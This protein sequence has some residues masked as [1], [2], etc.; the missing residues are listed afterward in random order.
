[1][2]T[3]SLA[4]A[5]AGGVLGVALALAGVRGLVAMAPEFLP[6]LKGIGVDGRVLGFTLLAALGSALAFGLLPALRASG[7]S[8]AAA[9]GGV[10]STQGKPAQRSR[11]LLVAF[12]LALSL[13]L[14]VGA[15]LLMR[16]FS[17]LMRTDPGFRTENLLT[18]SMTL[19]GER[20][21]AEGA[22]ESA[23]EQLLERIRALP[24]VLGAGAI[25]SLPLG[26]GG[27]YLGRAFLA[28]GQ[29]EPPGGEDLSGMWSV[30]TPG[31]MS[32]LG[33]PLLEGRDFTEADTADSQQVMIVS[34]EFARRMFPGQSAVGKRIR[35]WR[36][37]NV[38]RE[39]VGVVGDVR[40]F[41]ASDELRPLVFV[42]HRQN[43]WGL[44]SVAVR[45][46]GD[47]QALAGPIREVLRQMDPTLAIGQVQTMD[48][49]LAASV[50]PWKF[51]MTLMAVFAALALVLA[52]F[53]LYGV[54]SY[55]VTRRTREIGIRM[56]LGARPSAIRRLVLRDAG[57]L[58]AAG[59]LAGGAASLVVLRAM[60]SL[61]YGVGAA[62][63]WTLGC[64]SVLLAGVALLASWVPAQRAAHV[65]PVE[66]IRY[67]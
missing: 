52:V 47:P 14:L 38:Y 45:T 30:A 28:E 20:Y 32:V 4:L 40:Y 56:A 48:Q 27:F 58:V 65:E 13:L 54:L 11:N 22:A 6:R 37:E 5:L 3:E 31:T 15:G 53:G 43:A 8:A 12:E 67:E 61:L 24:G 19:Q 60:S 57:R 18:F 64:V 25:S 62:D 42:P 49:V 44:M 33:I 41:G 16:S 29:P 23:Y 55:A 2:L 59:V 36:D 34:S 1:M 51:G 10:R 39:V 7:L 50:A 9:V 35:S 46:Q 63:P 66:A 21:N 17:E 26:G